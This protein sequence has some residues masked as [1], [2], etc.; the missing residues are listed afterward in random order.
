MLRHPARPLPPRKQCGFTLVE[1]L[2]AVVILAIGLLGLA[3]L[4]LSSLQASQQA[5]LRSQATVLSQDIVERMRANRTAALNG[6]YDVAMADG[7]PTGADIAT[8]DLD[9]W[10]TALDTSLPDGDGEV[11]VNG[12]GVATVSVQWTERVRD[13]EAGAGTETMTFSTEVRL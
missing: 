9:D 3:G 11:S 2:V 4:Q 1:V 7:V 13:P 8:N 5:Y 12:N 6:D 10:L